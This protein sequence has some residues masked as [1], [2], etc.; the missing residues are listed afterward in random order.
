MQEL[1]KLG[2]K[3]S[4][5]LICSAVIAC[6]LWLTNCITNIMAGSFSS[7]SINVMY[8]LCIMTLCGASIKKENNVVQGMTGALLATYL[9]GNSQVLSSNINGMLNAGLP[10]QSDWMLIFGCI[11]SLCLFLTHFLLVNPKYHNMRRIMTNQII[12]IVLLLFRL[13]QG[14]MNLFGPGLSF[15]SFRATVGLFAIIPTLNVIVCAEN[16]GESYNS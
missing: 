13:I 7:V 3:R 10:S 8:I 12:I 4:S 2:F 16:M 1:L 6:C 15:E 14:L 5:L 9:F 11:L